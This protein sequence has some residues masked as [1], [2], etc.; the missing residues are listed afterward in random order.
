MNGTG[1]GSCQ[2]SAHERSGLIA[3]HTPINR[4]SDRAWNATKVPHEGRHMHIVRAVCAYQLLK[5]DLH[6]YIHDQCVYVCYGASD[7]GASALSVTHIVL[8][9]AVGVV[10]CVDCGASCSHYSVCKGQVSRLVVF[11]F[12]SLPLLFQAVV[13]IWGTGYCSSGKQIKLLC[14]VVLQPLRVGWGGGGVR[15][16][17]RGV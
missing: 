7:C 1:S 16:R 5:C 12:I 17:S 4:V 8:C 2:N 11:V 14:L 6:T 10:M 9:C 15:R 13:G 3:N